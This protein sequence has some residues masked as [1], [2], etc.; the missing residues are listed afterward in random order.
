VDGI[1]LSNHG[2]KV[3]ISSVLHVHNF[4]NRATIRI[5]NNCGFSFPFHVLKVYS[6]SSLPPI[7]VLYRL[8]QSRPDVFD[9]T[10]GMPPSRG[11]PSLANAI[12]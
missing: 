7:E 6:C 12:S 1:L 8:R 4:G 10:E 5:V 3:K 11:A 9:K 2:G